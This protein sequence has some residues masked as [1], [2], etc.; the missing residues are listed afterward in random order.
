MY[1]AKEAGVISQSRY[2]S[3]MKRK[4]KQPEFRYEMEK[5]L[6]PPETSDRFE[7]L[8]YRAF[9]SGMISESKASSLLNIPHDEFRR[10]NTVI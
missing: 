7:R 8:V 2:E 1:K 9:T 10:E 6:Y 4:N 5:S 3:C